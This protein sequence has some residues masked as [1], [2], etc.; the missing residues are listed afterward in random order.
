MLR[1]LIYSM[2]SLFFGI[3]MHSEKDMIHAEGIVTRNC[4]LRLVILAKGEII[5]EL[6]KDYHFS[7]FCKP[8][9]YVV[10]S[11]GKYIKIY[12]FPFCSVNGGQGH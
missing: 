5:L 1:S 11:G 2:P 10:K 4:A 12:F 7:V 3:K 6:V 9:Y 8:Y